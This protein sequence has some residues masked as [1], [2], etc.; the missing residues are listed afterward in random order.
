MKSFP[1][2]ISRAT[3]V[4]LKLLAVVISEIIER[5]KFPDAEV[6]GG[7]GGINAI[8]IRPEIADDVI[9]GYGADFSGLPCCE[10]VSCKLQQFFRK[11]KSATYVTR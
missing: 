1:V 8:C 5:K 4:D 6:G 9:S 10:F 7:A 2:E 3:V 11:S